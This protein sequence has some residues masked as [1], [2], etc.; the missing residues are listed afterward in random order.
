MADERATKKMKTDDINS[1]EQ[2]KNFTVIV[3][4]MFGNRIDLLDSFMMTS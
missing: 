2:L 1:L 3:G 4:N